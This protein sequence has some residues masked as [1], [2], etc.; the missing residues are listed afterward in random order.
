MQALFEAQ[1]YMLSGQYFFWDP[2]AAAILV[3]PQ[4]ATIV[5]R[6]V[7]VLE[8]EQDTQG[9]T[10]AD[11]AGA[12]IRVAVV[13]DALTFEREFLNTLNGDEAIHSTRPD[14]IATIEID[15]SGCVY[16]GPIDLPSGLVA[17]ALRNP[18]STPW[19]IALVSIA[20]G[21]TYTEIV[22]IVDTFRP[23][24]STG[25]EPPPWVGVSSVT[26]SEPAAAAL[27]P[28][29]LEPGSYGLVC[30]SQDAS[31]LQAVTGITAG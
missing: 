25:I 20:D 10:V 22:E 19:T 2:L 17:V 27:V 16:D 29:T 9:Q 12:P 14:P 6:T 15:A 26:L 21:H 13:A 23:T 24:D 11:P 3:D 30:Q 7:T 18:T 1:P 28:W 4:L 31:M 8:G 5:D